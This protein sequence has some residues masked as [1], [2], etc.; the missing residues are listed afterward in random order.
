MFSV[1]TRHQSWQNGFLSLLC[2]LSVF[3]FAP[4]SAVDHFNGVCAHKEMTMPPIIWGSHRGCSHTYMYVGMRVRAGSVPLWLRWRW[5][6]RCKGLCW[7][8]WMHEYLF[9]SI[10]D[11][12]V[13]PLSRIFGSS[14]SF[15]ITSQT[16]SCSWNYEDVIC[17]C[18]CCVTSVIKAVLNLSNQDAVS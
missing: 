10:R 11:V 5:S 15:S 3:S 13:T 6:A 9:A 8:V 12:R 16:L 1:C 2:P 17:Q 4:I 18:R 14:R 7:I